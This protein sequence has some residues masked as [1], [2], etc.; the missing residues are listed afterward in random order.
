VFD[1]VE[2][3]DERLE[4]LKEEILEKVFKEVNRRMKAEYFQ[5]TLV[6]TLSQMIRNGEVCDLI[7][8]LVQK[9]NACQLSKGGGGGS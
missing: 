1:S 7:E 4:K 5:Y 6:T 9:I 3:S 8:T 2:V